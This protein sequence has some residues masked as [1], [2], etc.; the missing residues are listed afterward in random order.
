MKKQNILHS[1]KQR[2]I[3]GQEDNLI[4][5]KIYLELVA[6]TS[7]SEQTKRKEYIFHTLLF[8][9]I[10]L[11]I[12]AVMY[13]LSEYFLKGVFLDW[14]TTPYIPIFSA[15]IF[16]FFFYVSKKRKINQSR[17]LFVFI[18]ISLACYTTALWGINVPQGL[19]LFG[20]SI[21]LSG[22]LI[23]SRAS[24]LFIALTTIS[25]FTIYF[26]HKNQILV[27]VISWKQSE[28]NIIDLVIYIGTFTLIAIIS[29]LSNTELERLLKETKHTAKQLE[30]ERNLLDIR[31][32]ERTKELE[33]AYEDLQK[34]EKEKYLEI[35]KLTTLGKLSTGLVHDIVDP[36]T[37][38]STSL[39]LALWKNKEVTKDVK[40]N[41]KMAL[42]G[43]TQIAKLIESVRT[44]IRGNT[45]YE[46]YSLKDVI[47]KTTTLLHYAS[48]SKKITITVNRYK[49][50]TLYGNPSNLY[51]CLTNLLSNAI[52]AY[53][54][55]KP[56]EKMRTVEMNVDTKSKNIVISVKDHGVG[57]EKEKLA[58][59]F[60]LF[61][62]TKPSKEGTGVGL[63]M[64][65][66]I[67]EKNLKG[68]IQC[69]SV[70][71]NFTTFTIIFP[72]RQ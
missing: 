41:I 32:K 22:I 53:K 24:V 38:I 26:L 31:V 42:H 16:A 40:R 23:S 46:K 25:L 14:K 57:I 18:V 33:K 4:P 20:L 15:A 43:S 9:T 45:I 63:T 62:T 35:N 58:H 56:L 68:T 29:W 5:T 6:G 66:E 65:K 13:N 2:W 28:T 60:D 67:I 12:I 34:L 51:Q 71:N 37:Y 69:T 30:K 1:L 54:M 27:P 10:C 17:Y 59:M 47:T 55:P 19:L 21:I 11:S 49:D 72:K 3:H 8:W 36:L 48:K 44:S 7:L 39:E 61:Y 64:C 52:E 70:Q 50:V